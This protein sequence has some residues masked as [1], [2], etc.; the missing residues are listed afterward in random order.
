M[1]GSS[2][3]YLLRP[4]FYDSSFSP[5]QQTKHAAIRIGLLQKTVIYLEEKVDSTVSL[6][7]KEEVKANT[8][9]QRV[10]QLEAYMRDCLT[11]AQLAMHESEARALAAEKECAELREKL[12]IANSYSFEQY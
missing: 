11:K 5:E 1:Q 10:D 9:Q 12:K 2:I 8:A 4:Y 7:S 6:L 3:P